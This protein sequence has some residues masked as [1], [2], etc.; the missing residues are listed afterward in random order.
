MG[1]WSGK[2]RGWEASWASGETFD[3]V[4]EIV[5]MEFDFVFEIV[6]MEFDWQAG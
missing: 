2:R 3:F 6:L 4:F 5:L 1:T